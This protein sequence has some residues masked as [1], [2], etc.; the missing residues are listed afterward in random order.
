MK[1]LIDTH[2]LLWFVNGDTRVSLNARDLIMCPKAQSYISIASYWEISIKSSL[3]KIDLGMTLETFI[4]RR[5]DEGFLLLAIEPKHITHLTTLPF[6]HRDPFDRLLISQAM[7]ENMTLC[8]HDAHFSHYP[9]K[10]AW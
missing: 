6:H 8:T 4:Q 10:T 1:V 2:T 5:M 7:V 9:I 3:G